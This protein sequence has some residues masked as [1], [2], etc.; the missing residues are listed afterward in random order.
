MHKP[1][2]YFCNLFALL[3][4]SFPHAESLHDSGLLKNIILNW[5]TAQ[6]SQVTSIFTEDVR[7]EREGSKVCMISRLLNIDVADDYAFDIDESVQVMVE[8]DLHKSNRD[9]TL[10]YDK[11]GDFSGGQMLLLPN[12]RKNRY[13]RHTFKLARARFAGR[14][15]GSDIGAVGNLVNGDFYLKSSAAMAVCNITL[16]RS[17]TTPQSIDFGRLA[18][19]IVDEAG[20]SLPGRVGIYDTT[21]RMPLPGPEAL[22][23]IYAS[24]VSRVV[25]L[26]SSSIF[27][28]ARNRQ[29]F[30]VNG[31]YHSRLPVGRYKIV[32]SR[33][34][35]YPIVQST[36]EINTGKETS[37]KLALTRWIDMASQGWYSGDGHVHFNRG[38][39]QDSVDILLQSKAE[40]LNLSNLIPIGRTLAEATS[41]ANLADL[42]YKKYNWG[43]EATIS[44]DPYVL[45]PGQEYPLTARGHALILNIRSPI[46][47]TGRHFLYHELFEKGLAQNGLTG[48]AHVSDSP[49]WPSISG[50]GLA[51]DVP[52]GLVDFVEILQLGV[53]S[54]NVWFDFLN[55]GYKLAPVAGTDYP[56]LDVPGAVRNY[57]YVGEPF[58]IKGWYDGVKA[59][60]TFITNGPILEFNINGK[61]IGSDVYVAKGGLLKIHAKAVISPSIS[62]LKSIQ[63]FQQGEIVAE[64]LFKNGVNELHLTHEIRSDRG[65]WFVIKALA[66][67]KADL[68]D[69]VAISAPIYVHSDGHGFCDLSKI[70][71]IVTKM[72]KLL[73]QLVAEKISDIYWQNNKPVLQQRIVDVNNKYDELEALSKDKKCIGN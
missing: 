27:W 38:N 28:P 37:V 44:D 50:G 60:R 59:G 24:G 23:I 66:K 9:I 53:V 56:F 63:L 46:V 68:E 30:Y 40:D 42:V 71:S 4:S 47:N 43:R 57:V 11:N 25:T 33:G 34:P 13:Y 2:A 70:S 20:N 41:G 16:K 19:D 52:Y 26:N 72:R 64:T 61:G 21:D 14:H 67:N 65:S 5:H 18:L 32:V 73:K 69:L 7:T 58:S 12:E 36:F 49:P 45:V 6:I 3:F 54:T 1:N 39:Y 51:L 8:F 15:I 48:Y 22:P 55:L 10:R 35:E 62:S 31:S 29:A 17:Y